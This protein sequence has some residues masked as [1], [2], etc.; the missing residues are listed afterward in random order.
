MGYITLTPDRNRKAASPE[1]AWH[2]NVTG[3]HFG[4][5]AMQTFCLGDGDNA[6]HQQAGNPTP[7]EVLLNSESQLRAT[8]GSIGIDDEV[9][10]SADDDLVLACADC[11]QQRDRLFEIGVGDQGEFGVAD[12]G[13]E[14]EEAGVARVLVEIEEGAAELWSVISAGRSD[15]YR[16]TVLQRGGEE[17]TLRIEAHIARC[18]I[19]RFSIQCSCVQESLVAV[20]GPS[21]GFYWENPGTDL[22][23]LFQSRTDCASKWL[24]RQ[25]P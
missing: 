7:L 23:A 22:W 6:P 9:T 18:K 25:E 15:S 8:L 16:G 24:V 20:A 5:K 14:S 10:R 11:H 3:K 13:L 19:S 12:I 4:H 1:D 2:R 21:R 17:M